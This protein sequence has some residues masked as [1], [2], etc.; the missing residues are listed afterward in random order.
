MCTSLWILANIAKNQSGS[1]RTQRSWLTC[2]VE[3]DQ[4][5]DPE[6]VCKET[7]RRTWSIGTRRNTHGVGHQ[8][9][10]DNLWW[11]AGLTYFVVPAI[12]HYMIRE[13]LIN[14]AK[15]CDA[16]V[17]SSYSMRELKG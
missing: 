8:Q 6:A 2:P 13:K 5:S 9:S 4:T 12:Y 3:P 17:Y 1:Q 11:S 10:S 7:R 15:T 16:D 14:K